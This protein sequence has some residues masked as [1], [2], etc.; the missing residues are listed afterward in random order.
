[1]SRSE[2]VG[3]AQ[4]VDYRTLARMKALFGDFRREVE[5]SKYSQNSKELR[6]AYVRNFIEWLEGIYSPG[7]YD[8]SLTP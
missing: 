5:A 1:M 6:M 8:G 3:M 7:D 4:R 2:E